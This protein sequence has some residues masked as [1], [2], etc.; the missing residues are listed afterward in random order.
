MKSEEPKEVFFKEST[1]GVKL[2]ER[3]SSDP[4]ILF[5][6]LIEDDESWRET[7]FKVSSYFIDETIKVLKKAKKYMEKQT[8]DGNF[9]YKFQK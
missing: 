6:L 8:K 7:N 5:S 1:V 9:G 2:S 3:G 4:H